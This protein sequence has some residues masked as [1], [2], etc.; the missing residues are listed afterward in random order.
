MFVL[1]EGKVEILREVGGESVRLAI[2][3]QGAI[4]GEMGVL[5]DKPRSTTVRSLTDTKFVV[6]PK[7]D[8]LKAFGGKNSLALKL[9]RMLCGRL[10]KAD[11]YILE[12]QDTKASNGIEKKFGKIRLLPA[13]RAIEIQIGLDGIEITDFPY[14]IGRHI[15][16]GRQTSVSETGLLFRSPENMPVAGR[17]LTIEER[18]SHLI[19]RDLGSHLG[20]MVNG[21]RIADF[22]ESMECALRF[23]DNEIQ[24]GGI[25][26]PYKFRI[27]VD[28]ASEGEEG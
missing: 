14:Y 21:V 5:R 27:I 7:V 17:H 13:S 12:H 15:K 25:E 16:S 10:L 6:L 9:L 11:E 1:E 2:L 22:E 28:H 8:F 24:L 19:A 23:G 20:T 26:S 3:S 4:F 18:D